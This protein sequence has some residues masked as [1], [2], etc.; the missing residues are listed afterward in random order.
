[1][2]SN[3]FYLITFII[4]DIRQCMYKLADNFLLCLKIMLPMRY[5]VLT[6]AI[7]SSRDLRVTSD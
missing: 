4:L 1:V 2:D 6:K 3:L 7:L 5:N